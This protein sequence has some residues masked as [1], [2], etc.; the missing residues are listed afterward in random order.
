[1]MNNQVQDVFLQYGE[2]YRQKNKLPLHI[3]K[4]MSAIEKCRTSA[5]GGHM[6]ICE[7]CRGVQISYNSC[8]NRHCPKCQTL[9]R[10]RWV[11]NQKN[12][13]LNVGYF[14]VVFTIPDI[15]N[16]IVFQ[17]QRELYNLLF[18]AS[19]ETLAE[20]A[21]DKKHLGAKI[22]HTSVLH[23]WGQNLMHH[24]H[25]HCIVPGGGLSS[26]G[27]WVNSRKKFFIPVKV[28][29]RKFRGKYLFYLKQLYY[30]NKLEFHGNQ[31]YLSNNKDF[32]NLLSE[33]YEKEWVVYCKPPFKNASS[34]VEYLGRYTHRVAISNNRIVNTKDGIVTFKWRDY[35]DASK[36]KLMTVCAG[37]F[38][39]RFLIHILPSRFMKIKHYGLLSNRNKSIKLALCKRLTNTNIIPV[40]KASTLDL[41]QKI[42]GR[43]LSRCPYCGSDKHR[44]M[45]LGKSPPAVTKIA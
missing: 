21:G 43:D 9:A 34:V 29:S 7:D 27:K 3:H 20:L 2:S 10:E 14:H 35:K 18:Q 31:Q 40:E 25:V 13:L 12:N 28:L 23:T 38:I 33:L 36:W 45:C 6:I 16:S 22:G 37:E 11:D 39:R 4:A 1:M 15:L 41:L 17:N 32:E 44:F 42:S 24:P 19:A 8:R 5:L 30:Q 26:L